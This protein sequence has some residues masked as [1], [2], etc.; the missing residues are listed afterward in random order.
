MTFYL[1]DRAAPRKFVVDILMI[2]YNPF[3]D[4]Q[5]FMVVMD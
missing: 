1:N 4:G 2:T 5:Y 3:S